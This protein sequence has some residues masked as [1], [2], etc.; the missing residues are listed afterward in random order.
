MTYRIGL[1]LHKMGADDDFIAD[2]LKSIPQVYRPSL[3]SVDKSWQPNSDPADNSTFR[4]RIRT[5]GDEFAKFSS[6]Y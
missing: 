4:I 2:C 5:P 3:R 1:R 6:H